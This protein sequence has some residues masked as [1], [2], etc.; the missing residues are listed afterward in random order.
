MKRRRPAHRSLR[1]PIYLGCEGASEAGYAA[2]LQDFINE[3][4]RP[5]YLKIDDL[6]RGA[7]DPLARVE[8]AVMH[9]AQ[10]IRRRTAPDACF[11]LLDSDQVALDAQRAERAQR[12]AGENNITLVWQDP[13][14]EALLLRHLPKRATCRPL[15]SRRANEALIRDWNDYKKPMTRA[16]L[17]RLINMDAVKRAASVEPGLAQLLRV[18][19]L[20]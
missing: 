7:G 20:M 1:R 9:I 11:I 17:A 15:N 6:G 10:Q 18:V 16:Q 2:L 5:F 13:C 4:D 3:A 12:M 14:F 19:E 8:M